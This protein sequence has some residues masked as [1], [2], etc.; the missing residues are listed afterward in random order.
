MKPPISVFEME[1]EPLLLWWLRQS[2]FCL[3]CRRPKFDSWLWKIPWRRGRQ[4]TSIF[5]PG[6]FHGQRTPGGYSL[7]GSQ[8]AGHLSDS[9]FH[10]QD[11]TVLV[12]SP[13]PEMFSAC[14]LSVENF[15]RIISSKKKKRV[16]S[17]REQEMLK[18][19]K[20]KVKRH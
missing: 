20:N 9:H 3:Q 11:P 15:S 17:T 2:R 13:P 18:L 16:S 7:W 10:F 5:L 8:G 12:P 14:L 6:E 1:Q 19:K 4:P